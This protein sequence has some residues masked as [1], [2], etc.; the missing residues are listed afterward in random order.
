MPKDKFYASPSDRKWLAPKEASGDVFAVSWGSEHPGVTIA[1]VNMDRS[2][3]NRLIL[4]VRKARD[5]V[6]GADV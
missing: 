3:L 5:Q 1:G 2:E 4:L 6:F